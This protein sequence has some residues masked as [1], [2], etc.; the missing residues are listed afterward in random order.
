MI[1]WIGDAAER[2]CDVRITISLQL[3]CHMSHIARRNGWNCTLIW[4][5]LVRNMAGIEIQDT[6]RWLST[7]PTRKTVWANVGT[8]GPC[9]RSQASWQLPRK[10]AY[11]LIAAQHVGTH[12]PC[13]RLTKYVHLLGIPPERTHEPCVPTCLLST[14]HLI[15][16]LILKFNIQ[17]SIF[18]VCKS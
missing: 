12:G 17:T 5:K 8:H 7:W 3:P 14:I 11:K 4:L 13:V 2:S 6:S 9:V 16:L 10:Q 15:I 18:K 1:L